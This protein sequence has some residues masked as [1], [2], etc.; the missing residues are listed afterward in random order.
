MN[1]INEFKIEPNECFKNYT[2][3][4]NAIRSNELW[5]D[6]VHKETFEEENKCD[7]HCDNISKQV[8]YILN[9]FDKWEK[10]KKKIEEINMNIRYNL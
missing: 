9:K 2:V 1:K 5:I 10:D 7:I 4:E 3:M 8:C 6:Y